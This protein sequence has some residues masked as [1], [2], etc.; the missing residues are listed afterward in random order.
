MEKKEIE[1]KILAIMKQVFEMQDID[2]T[3]SQDNC[4]RWDSL[5]HLD[6]VVELEDAF[7]IEFE[8]EEI[9]EMKTFDAV[10]K[11]IFSKI[12]KDK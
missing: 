8:P 7:G 6:L 9:A 3:C 1:E 12:N 10:T 4:E 5:H 11:M 2:K